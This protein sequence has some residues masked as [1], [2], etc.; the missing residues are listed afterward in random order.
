MFILTGTVNYKDTEKD[1]PQARIA[2][3]IK[4]EKANGATSFVFVVS[5][6]KQ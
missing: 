2:D 6:A 1:L 5:D 3:I 4:H